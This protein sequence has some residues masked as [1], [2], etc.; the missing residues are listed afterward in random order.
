MRTRSWSL[1]CLALATLLVGALAAGCGRTRD[2]GVTVVT[3]ATA[4]AATSQLVRSEL[5][6]Q[7]IAHEGIR[8]ETANGTVTLFGSVESLAERSAAE[9]AARA[10]AGVRGV[11]NELSVGRP[12]GTRP[13]PRQRIS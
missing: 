8:I 9:A 10:V 7:G 13:A 4:D 3:L 5:S 11:R 2:T 12:F 6:D 1:C